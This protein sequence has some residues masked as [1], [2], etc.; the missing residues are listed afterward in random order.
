MSIIYL[1]GVFDLFHRGHLEALRKS[2]LLGDKLIIGIISDADCKDY[3]REPIINE[4]DRCEII[5]SINYVDDIIFP[6]PLII[7]KKFLDENKIDLV[8]HSFSDEADFE[9][10]K[11]FFK[12]CIDNNKF[13]KINYYTKTSTTNIINKI[14]HI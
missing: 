3:K 10:Q 8:V 6:A 7:T 12:V 2:K 11:D 4:I 13:K 14:K 5:K 9:R 1:D